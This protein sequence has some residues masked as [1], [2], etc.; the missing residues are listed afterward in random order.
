MVKTLAAVLAVSGAVWFAAP[1]PAS[2]ATAHDGIA[3]TAQTDLG[4]ARRHRRVV[5]RRYYDA[6]RYYGYYGPTYYE[7]PYAR[8]TPL[9][10]GLGGYW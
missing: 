10:L 8:P 5:V 1:A 9:F 2:A 4:A 3:T 7:R 6:P